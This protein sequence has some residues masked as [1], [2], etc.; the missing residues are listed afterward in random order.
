[1]SINKDST[2]TAADDF[3]DEMQQQQQLGTHVLHDVSSRSIGTEKRATATTTTSTTMQS[4][5]SS[6]CDRRLS[7]AARSLLFQQLKYA[8]MS[9][10]NV[11]KDRKHDNNNN[12][13]DDDVSML[14]V[15]QLLERSLAP[16]VQQQQ[17]HHNNNSNQCP[18][19]PDRDILRYHEE[20]SIVLR[21]PPKAAA[22][23]RLGISTRSA[24]YRLGT[25]SWKHTAWYECGLCG[26]IFS[27]QY[28]LDRHLDHHHA[29]EFQQQSSNDDNNNNSINN[30]PTWIF[31]CPATS[32]CP[33]LPSCSQRAMELEPYYGPGSGGLGTYDQAIVR[34]SLWNKES[35]DTTAVLYDSGSGAGAAA[36]V[37]CN[38]DHMRAQKCICQQLVRDCFTGT[39][40]TTTTTTTFDHRQNEI[41]RLLEHSLCEPISC[42]DRLHQLFLAATA[43]TANTA[44]TTTTMMMNHVHEWHDQ[45]E[46]YYE[47][48]HAFGRMGAALLVMLGLWYASHFRTIYYNRGFLLRRDKGNRLLQRG[49]GSTNRKTTLQSLKAKLQ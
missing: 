7:R 37:P 34:R 48:H 16:N 20:Q 25:H 32:W 24:L 13:D 5:H 47:Q 26:K 12:N 38:E 31:T 17:Q 19:L 41:R 27:S 2:S 1:M 21:P 22:N 4:A 18:L 3:A 39:T 14:T 10:D 23:S 36:T 44:A 45:W 29:H 35:Y 49:G 30:G 40:T 33:G 6:T 46:Q 15:W 9:V 11:K 42:P 8:V 43:T 28:Y